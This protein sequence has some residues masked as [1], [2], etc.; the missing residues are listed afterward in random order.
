[1][2]AQPRAAKAGASLRLRSQVR[3]SRRLRLT[4]VPVTVRNSNYLRVGQIVKF[5][6]MAAIPLI[7]RAYGSP[8]RC[9]GRSVSAITDSALSPCREKGTG[10]GRSS[11]SCRR[12]LFVHMWVDQAQKKIC[13]EKEGD[14]R[15][16]DTLVS[17]THGRCVPGKGA[18]ADENRRQPHS[19][20][21]WVPRACALVELTRL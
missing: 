9:W 4:S 17:W 7:H 2:Q 13:R 5:R 11:R 8:L 10:L 3:T 6:G 15:E 1:M 14:E 20:G 12:V 16:F 18:A 21:T 19:I